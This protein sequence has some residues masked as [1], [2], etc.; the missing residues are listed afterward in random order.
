MRII[1][2]D[3]LKC[4]SIIFVV[5][6]HFGCVDFGDCNFEAG[7]GYIPNITKILYE[8]FACSV[9]LFFMVNG[10]LLQYNKVSV[11]KITKLVFLSYLYPVIFY[12]LIFP[13]LHFIPNTTIN[14]RYVMLSMEF[15]GV[16]WFLFT[17]SLI[18][19]V[20]FVVRRLKISRVI[21]TLL[22][23]SPFITN[24]IWMIIL[25]IIPDI[26][27]PFWGHW[28][29]FTLYGYLYFCIGR[30]LR[31]VE[32]KNCIKKAIMLIC[33]GWGL[34]IWEVIL[35]SNHYK[36]IYDGVNASFP[37]L[38][39]LLLSCG[40]FLLIKSMPIRSCFLEKYVVFIGRNTMGIYV[41]HMFFIYCYRYW[42]S[43]EPLHPLIAVLLSLI[44]VN[45]TALISD[46]LSRT[47]FQ[48][49]LK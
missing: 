7:G 46:M 15:K 47:R 3:I 24:L 1:Y 44:I 2:L 17:L 21:L 25:Q 23:V 32:C 31:N 41:F 11:Q 49:F 45:L 29:M 43:E 10:A 34:L 13:V 40:M 12:L 36:L 5:T 18:Y 42:F 26:D 33:I 28:G 35:F 19:V 8:L 4:L 37:S 14:V 27:L 48:Y 6:Y 9:P 30:V 16:Y 20:D 22:F 38:G 39:A